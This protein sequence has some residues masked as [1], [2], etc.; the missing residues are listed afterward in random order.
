MLL[1]WRRATYDIRGWR[2]FLIS[3]YF[4]FSVPIIFCFKLKTMSMTA[5]TSPGA[6]TIVETCL[7]PGETIP[8]GAGPTV[9]PLHTT[10]PRSSFP[11]QGWGTI[12]TAETLLR[13]LLHVASRK[14]SISSGNTAN[15]R[16]STRTAANIQ[17]VKS[18][19]FPWFDIFVNICF[20][21]Y[22]WWLIVTCV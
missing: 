8:A 10:L 16:S 14:T 1:S 18:F 12:T 17:M 3:P 22:Y 21:W 5:T 4:C 19:P 9:S 7:R 15:L 2:T 6:W 13:A 20:P 11:K